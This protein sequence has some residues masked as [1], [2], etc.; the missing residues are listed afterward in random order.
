MNFNN[1]NNE[2]INHSRSPNIQY[3]QHWYPCF[4]NQSESVQESQHTQQQQQHEPKKR[5]RGNRK[6]QRYRR[7]LRKQGINPDTICLTDTSIDIDSNNNNSKILNEPVL[8]TVPL[9]NDTIFHQTKITTITT[10]TDK[11]HTHTQKD[12]LGSAGQP[13]RD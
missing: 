3:C 5:C 11:R 4:S 9:V 13:R 1:T 2:V 12:R 7:K 8:S 6:L 10:K